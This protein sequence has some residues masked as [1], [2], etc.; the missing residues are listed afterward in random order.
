MAALGQSSIS[1]AASCAAATVTS[2]VTPEVPATF[3]A[4]R[5]VR[6][7]RDYCTLIPDGGSHLPAGQT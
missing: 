6:T 3:T 1:Q 5:S 4:T 2:P 7:A